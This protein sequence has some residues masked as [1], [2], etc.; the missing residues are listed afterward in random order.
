MSYC[1]TGKC[2]RIFKT[3]SGCDG[4]EG[5]LQE[6]RCVNGN[7][8]YHITIKATQKVKDGYKFKFKLLCTNDGL[9]PLQT[10]SSPEILL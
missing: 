8:C 7:N 10:I 3:A 1:G 2:C 5:G 6:P 9:S 4:T